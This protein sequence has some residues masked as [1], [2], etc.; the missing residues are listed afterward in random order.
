MSPKGT[1]PV[2]V[3]DGSK[4]VAESEAIARFVESTFKDGPSLIPGS[5]RGAV[6][7][8]FG[9][10]NAVNTEDLVSLAALKAGNAAAKVVLP[11][12]AEGTLARLKALAENPETSEETKK[13]IP[14][15][16]ALAKAKLTKYETPAESYEVVAAAFKELLDAAE[17]ALGAP[18][19]G[20]DKPRFLA[21]G[22]APS[23]ADLALVSVLA[24]AHWAA[25]PRQAFLSRP[26]LAAFYAHMTAR[27][28]FER[29]DVWSGLK[30]VAGALLL[31]EAAID[32]S[33][34]L[35]SQAAKEWNTNLAPPL[36]VAWHTVADPVAG[37][38][39]ATGEATNKYVV[40]P[41]TD[42]APFKATA[43]AYEVSVAPKLRDAAHA[44]GEFLQE[45]V[46]TPTKNASAR[47]G[48]MLS[49]AASATAEAA[50]KAAAATASA[51][52]EAAAKAGEAAKSA[53]AYTAE[54]AS[55]AATATKEAAEHAATATKA[56]AESAAAATKAAAEHAATAT[57]AAADSAKASMSSSSP[58]SGEAAAE[59]A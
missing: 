54:A 3:H 42:S 17:A 47:A 21:G 14:A 46:F 1:V 38:A 39:R 32:A 55:K 40:H 34:L 5:S 48:A 20:D 28:A 26:A 23:L 51:T 10:V 41:I 33:V 16:E 11:Q 12:L 18:V 30:P 6:D 25:E 29:A 37:A 27:P 8:F 58:K 36:G 53:A 52:K 50:S 49:A 44:T 24:R 13:I 45:R 57:K 35:W 15:K 22:D 59:T 43:L 9:L 19:E 31:G 2:L 56:A 4:V 7:K